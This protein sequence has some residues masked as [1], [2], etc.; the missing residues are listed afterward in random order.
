MAVKAGAL[1]RRVQVRRAVLS[2][3][4]LGQ[5]LSWADH[6]APVW[7]AKKDISDGERWRAAEVQAHVTTRFTLRWSPFAAG[8]TPKDHLV[9]EGLEY[10]ITGVKEGPGRRVSIEITAAARTDG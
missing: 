6:G 2:D 9:C 1:D 10:E 8:I 3:D 5:V 7:A 4:G